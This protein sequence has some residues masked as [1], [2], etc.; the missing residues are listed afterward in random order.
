MNQAVID[1]LELYARMLYFSIQKLVNF[2]VI[3]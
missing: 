2:E 3:T 1:V